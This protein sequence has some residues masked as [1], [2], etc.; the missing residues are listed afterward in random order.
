M[1]LVEPRGRGANALTEGHD[2]LAYGWTW[3]G[4]ESVAVT[5]HPRVAAPG[6]VSLVQADL[7][8]S[9]RLRI[10]GDDGTS[11]SL[12]AG[13]TWTKVG[14]AKDLRTGSSAVTAPHDWNHIVLASD[15]GATGAEVSRDGGRTWS[16]SKGLGRAYTMFLDADGQNAWSFGPSIDRSSD[17]GASFMH[18]EEGASAGLIVAG[19][20]SGASVLVL[21]ASDAPTKTQPEFL[22]S[23]LRFDTQRNVATSRQVLPLTPRRMDPRGGWAYTEGDRVSAVTLVP[24][25]PSALC[26]GIE[27]EPAWQDHM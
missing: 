9:R 18:V 24:G 13:A 21:A 20:Q 10:L 6:H 14:P 2:G 3:N 23:I 16:P 26:I 25:E 22:E 15:K 5:G 19:A 27:K 11:E 17:G 7:A 1:P 4:L 12:D 8:D